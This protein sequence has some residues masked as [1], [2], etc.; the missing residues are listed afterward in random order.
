MDAIRNGWGASGAEGEQIEVLNAMNTLARGQEHLDGRVTE[1]AS[2]LDAALIVQQQ[3]STKGVLEQTDALSTI[4]EELIALRE[5]IA[6]QGKA[7][8]A[9]ESL[10]GH[11]SDLP[12]TLA[13][14][15]A[16]AVGREMRP[17]RE[18]IEQATTGLR[19]TMTDL[20][21]VVKGARTRKRQSWTVGVTAALTLLAGFA[22]YPVAATMLPGGSELARVA[23][24]EP[25]RWQA[26]WA[27]LEAY[28]RDLRDR[29]ETLQTLYNDNTEALA[30]CS[31][32]VRTT[33]K[34]QRCDV[35]MYTPF[36]VTAS[37]PAGAW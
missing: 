11:R 26:G 2:R 6:S 9:L 33:G 35:E 8:A 28:D 18:G 23:T 15:V 24:G 14:T 36:P 7:I 12:A 22:A 20:Q 37:V 31:R 34:P 3:Q 27:L 19:G 21:S 25:N 29:L 4:R 10:P 30:A 5:A 1:I 16:N 32:T 13:Q 17:A